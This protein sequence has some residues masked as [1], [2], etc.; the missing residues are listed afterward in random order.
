MRRL[1]SFEDLEGRLLCDAAPPLPLVGSGPLGGT[2]GG[3]P[4][5]PVPTYS[6]LDLGVLDTLNNPPAPRDPGPIIGD[7]N[8]PSGPIV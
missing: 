1:V 2:I 5:V 4:T 6:E 8:P 7:I 3:S